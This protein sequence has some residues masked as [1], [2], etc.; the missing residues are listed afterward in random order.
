MAAARPHLII[1]LAA[2]E[3]FDQARFDQLSQI[4]PVLHAPAGEL[5]WQEITLALGEPLDLAAAAEAS[6]EQA[7]TAIADLR[8]AHPEF[9][10]NTAAHVIVYEEQ[11]G[12]AYVSAPGSDTAALFEALGFTLPP[13]ADQFIDDDL[14]SL[15]LAGLIDA[16]FLL[17]S[18]FP[19]S[20]YF[21]D[22]PVVQ[23]VPAVADS[24]A[25]I[26]PADEETGINYFA[27]GLNVPSVV[28]VPWLLDQLADFGSE[29]LS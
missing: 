26:N 18:T 15:E 14:V 11:W 10:G 4:A 17:I 9:E 29:A 20:E 2:Y 22:S 27:W 7:E 6:V 16:D 13:A 21:L 28:S 25:V 24:R 19:G 3:T 23:A 1:S 12:T 8:E 5:S